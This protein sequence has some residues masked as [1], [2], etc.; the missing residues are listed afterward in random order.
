MCFL[1]DMD[2]QSAM[3]TLIEALPYKDWIAGV[4]LDSDERDNPPSKFSD[5]FARAKQEGWLVTCH[6]DIDQK[7]SIEHIRQAL[8]DIGVNRIDHGTNI[9]EDE[10]LVQMV[11][12]KSLGLTCCPV[13][14][15][16]VTRDFKGK[17][18]LQLLRSGVNVTIN[19]DDPAYFRGYVNENLMKMV[20]GT[21]ISKEELLTLQKNAFEI[22]W[23]SAGKKEYFLRLL[24]KY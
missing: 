20:N 17:E 22:S 15:S 10:R 18:I 14:N 23:I 6:C 1:R 9:V 19:S 24:E 2:A 11:K 8:E 4:G 5:V 12:E 13:S 16:V 3:D 7:N 21:N